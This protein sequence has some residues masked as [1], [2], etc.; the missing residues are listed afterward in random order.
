MVEGLPLTLPTK[1]PRVF[2]PG[3]LSSSKSFTPA[4]LSLTSPS[5]PSS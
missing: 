1:S 2:W 5:S 3:A 4:L